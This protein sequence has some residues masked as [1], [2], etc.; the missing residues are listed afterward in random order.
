[1]VSVDLTNR[2]GRSLTRSTQSI[3]LG[4][5]YVASNV[6]LPQ[7]EEVQV[8]LDLPTG[9]FEARGSVAYVLTSMW[10]AVP[11]VQTGMGIR[12]EEI[13]PEEAPQLARFIHILDRTMRGRV[14]IVDD[15]AF[16]A[17]MMRDALRELSYS[18]SVA[19]DSLTALRVLEYGGIDAV[20]AEC[21]L[22]RMDALELL[23]AANKH[24]R[25]PRVGWVLTSRS[26]VDSETRRVAARLGAA[27]L[28]R[29][30]FLLESL[31]DGVDLALA[32]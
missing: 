15:D 24:P 12:F 6:W 14:L 27:A 20:V 16:Y 13:E 26:L 4:G 2:E 18:V 10:E 5:L 9:P 30:P 11:R 32:A 8:R 17:N 31:L 29:K 23:D 25:I 21:Y 22:P 28:L 1:M 7:G 3:S 19:G